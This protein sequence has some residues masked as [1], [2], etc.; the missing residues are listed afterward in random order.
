MPTQGFAVFVDG[1]EADIEE[2]TASGSTV[3]LTLERADWVE[4]GETVTISYTPPSSGQLVD[5]RGNEAVAVAADVLEVENNV[6]DPD[7]T[8]PPMAERASVNEDGST[9]SL[10]F[11]EPVEFK[12]QAPQM[13]RDLR[14]LERTASTINWAWSRPLAVTNSFGAAVYYEYRVAK[15]VGGTFTANWTRITG[16]SV[17]ITGLD[18]ETAY[19]IQVRA[20]NSGGTSP[21]ASDQATTRPT[22]PA[23]GDPTISKLSSTVFIIWQTRDLR[24]AGIAPAGATI[25]VLKDG[26]W[27][28]VAQGNNEAGSF[29]TNVSTTG[30]QL[31]LDT[32]VFPQSG[33]IRIRVAFLDSN[34][35]QISQLKILD[36]AE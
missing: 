10:S 32:P 34:S 5:R 1:T 19:E 29:F 25:E 30:V 3:E 8:D 22:I 17:V 2:I 26:S 27:T 16:T 23:A 18:P 33:A 28:E 13:I 7:E 21:V 15:A 12:T 6:L 11:D 24:N 31:R 36:I 4:H 9:V 14:E 35:N 20:G